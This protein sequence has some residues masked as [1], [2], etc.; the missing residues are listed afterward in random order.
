LET[1]ENLVKGVS[2]E[3][4]GGAVKNKEVTV[5]QVSVVQGIENGIA[6]SLARVVLADGVAGE[7]ELR[8]RQIREEGDVKFDIEP[9]TGDDVN[10][11][12][13]RASD[14]PGCE[15]YKRGKDKK[16]KSSRWG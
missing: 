3:V 5:D 9:V 7:G 2:G 15:I 11:I 16:V 6:E 10:A 1:L 14:P 13:N 12:A 4:N 8:S